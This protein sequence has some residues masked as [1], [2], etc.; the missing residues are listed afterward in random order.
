MCPA[1]AIR[2]RVSSRNPRSTVATS[3]EVHD[4]LR[5]LFAR[6]GRVTCTACGAEVVRDTPESAADRLRGRSSEGTSYALVGFPLAVGGTPRAGPAG[7]PPEAGL[8]RAW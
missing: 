8:P 1:V 3:T 2:Q 6:A 5:M 4:H 7:P